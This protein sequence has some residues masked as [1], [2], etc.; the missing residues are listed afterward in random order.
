M[1][2]TLYARKAF[3]ACA[4]LA[5][6][7]AAGPA[8]AHAK[9]LAETPPSIEDKAASAPAGPVTSLRL[10]FSEDLVAAFSKAEIVDVSGA[11]VPATVALDPADSK[12]LIVT[13]AT[14]LPA[15]TYTVNWKAVSADGHKI[16]GTYGI[17][18]AN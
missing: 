10:T 16:T 4:S 7:L 8:F 14:P 11:T 12:I 9:L 5:L 1:I 2:T 3:L 17:A 13:P 15:G 18:V 6:A